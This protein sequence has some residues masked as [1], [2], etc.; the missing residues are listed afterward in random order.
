[1]N[2]KGMSRA[3]MN[4]LGVAQNAGS[5]NIAIKA[6]RNKDR[7]KVESQKTFDL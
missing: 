4:R 6:W 5:E 7:S 2:I 1:M 3:H